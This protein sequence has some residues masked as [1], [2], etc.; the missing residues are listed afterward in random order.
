[1]LNLKEEALRWVR[2]FAPHVNPYVGS[3]MLSNTQDDNAIIHQAKQCAKNVVNEFIK[4][5]N[6]DTYIGHTYYEINHSLLRAIDSL[7]VDD[8]FPEDDIEFY[9]ILLPQKPDLILRVYR[10][11]NDLNNLRFCDDTLVV[12]IRGK[13]QDRMDG[14]RLL[15]QVYTQKNIRL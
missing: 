6:N 7:T 9:N 12:T 10:K 14:L 1:M 3:G 13:D 11:D 2:M 15:I 4:S 5:F 8:L